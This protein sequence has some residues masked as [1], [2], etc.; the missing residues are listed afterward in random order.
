MNTLS[1]EK[2]KMVVGAL[3]EGN[4]IRAT[5]RMTGV[6]KKTVMRILCEVGKA[7]WEYQ[8]KSL[9]N[10]PCKRI[11][12]DEIWS[13][14]YAKDR[15]LPEG[16]RDKWGYGSVWTWTA[17]CADTKIVPCW[18]IGQR[19]IHAS[20]AFMRDLAD[21][22]SDQ[23]QITTDG[24]NTYLQAVLGAFGRNANYGQI[25][26]RYRAM[27]GMT[28]GKYS[29]GECVSSYSMHVSGNPDAD[30]ISTSCVER[31]NLTMRMS[32]RRFTRLTNG[33]SKKIQNLQWAVSLHFMNYNFCRIHSSLRVTPAMAAKVTNKVWEIEDV[34]ALAYGIS[35]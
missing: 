10:L 34:L 18:F 29:P 2:R 13:F 9:V 12:C 19:D 26:K 4:S 30:H 21:R 35:K 32:M 11:E 28:E 14:C 31:Q 16:K 22:V 1:T 25:V 15:N 27:P 17:I 3:V 24:H 7:C 5:V 8:Q 20:N 23:V 33:F 6:A